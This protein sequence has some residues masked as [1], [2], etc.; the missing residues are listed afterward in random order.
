MAHNAV[1]AEPSEQLMDLAFTALDHAADSVIAGGGPLVPF[2]LLEVEGDRSLHRFVGELEQAQ[3]QARSAVRSTPN[4]TRGAVA[5]DGY[6]TIEGEWSDAVFVEAS[7]VGDESSV[8]LAQ[9][10]RVVGRIRKKVESFGNA[11]LVERGAP[12]F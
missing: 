5:W 4:I 3:L 2:C 1:V 6:L 10:Y 9:R 7:E 8:V 11:V 12:L